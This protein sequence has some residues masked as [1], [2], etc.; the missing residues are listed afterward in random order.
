MGESISAVITYINVINSY[1]L[2]MNLYNAQNKLLKLSCRQNVLL[3]HFKDNH[4][5]VKTAKAKINFGVLI[6]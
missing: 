1:F 3:W 5:I 4:R 6:F 2:F